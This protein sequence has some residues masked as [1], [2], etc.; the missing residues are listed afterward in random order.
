MGNENTTIVRKVQVNTTQ[1]LNGNNSTTIQENAGFKAG[2]AN[3][4]VAPGIF[5]NMKDNAGII[6]DGNIGVPYNNNLSSF[7]RTRTLFSPDV[8]NTQA[9]VTPLTVTLPINEKISVS[10]KPTYIG[11]YD[12]ANEAWSNNFAAAADVSYGLNDKISVSAGA[13]LNNLEKGEVNQ[14]TTCISSGINV[15]F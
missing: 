3:L 14:N 6:I 10:A 7:A 4:E 11:T 2:K 8:K 15:K 12:I 13:I 1:F 9:W 5:T